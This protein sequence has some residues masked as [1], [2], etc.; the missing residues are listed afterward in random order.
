MTHDMFSWT[1]SVELTDTTTKV[2]PA[3]WQFE[4]LIERWKTER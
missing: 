3:L 1:R 2:K 4:S